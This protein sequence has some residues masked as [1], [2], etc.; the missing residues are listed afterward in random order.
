MKFKQL[1]KSGLVLGL[2]ATLVACSSEPGKDTGNT[3]GT[4]ADT[5]DT[6]VLGALGPYD[7]D[8]SVYGIAV[9][10]G[11]DLAIS[12][13]NE[14]GKTLLGKTIKLVTY[15]TKGDNTEATNAYNK[16]IDNDKAV[17]IVGG[18]LSG[19]STA[20]G[21]ASQGIGTPIL[22]PSATAL[23]FTETGDNAFRG[24]FTDPI[25]AKMMAEFAYDTLGHK[26]A[27]VI[28]NTG[29]D[30]SDGL[31]ENFKAAF[32][33]KGGQVLG[34]EGY[35]DGDKDFNSQLTKIKELNADVIYIPNYY[36]DI[37]LIAKQAR[38]LGIESQFIGGDG[39]DGVLSV[40][41]DA[42]V[43]EGAVFCNHYS[44]DDANIIA[45]AEKYEA[46]YGIE[47]ASFA[48]LGYDCANLMI[49]AIEEAGSTDSA[50]IVE[51]LKNIS[52]D[53][54]LGHLEFDENGDP[55]KD[56]AYITIKDG[57]YT[58]YQK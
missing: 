26:T 31:T 39:W 29:S 25:Q 43:L 49:Q 7:G 17:A 52:F 3:N 51:A 44:P 46:K 45:W 1:V 27:A 15:D 10:N 36:Q 14:A 55:I 38:A 9:K 32:E 35:A 58:S 28:Y 30:Y 24:C 37:A 41:D 21:S 22:S 4:T 48:F 6:I 8:Y 2:A 12:E 13:Y 57:K 18:V 34:V 33:A 16:L 23:A 56:L 54:V 47:P 40:T 50:A 5:G 20:V 53:G 11:I 42:S 19:E